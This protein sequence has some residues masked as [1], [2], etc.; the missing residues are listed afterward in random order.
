MNFE[1]L[2]DLEFYLIGYVIEDTVWT[3]IPARLSPAYIHP[4]EGGQPWRVPEI[5]SKT[6]N[7]FVYDGG[8]WDWEYTE[9][10]VDHNY[11][12]WARLPR[13]KTVE[14]YWGADEFH[15]MT[16][17]EEKGYPTATDIDVGTGI[18]EFPPDYTNYNTLKNYMES[19]SSGLWAIIDTVYMPGPEPPPAEN[20][21]GWAKTTFV[22]WVLPSDSISTGKNWL[23]MPDSTIGLLFKFERDTVPA[24]V[25][26]RY[27][28]YGISSWQGQCMN[29]PA[30][31]PALLPDGQG[32][33]FDFT[34][35]D[36]AKY[37]VAIYDFDTLQENWIDASS[38]ASLTNTSM[39]RYFLTYEL[40]FPEDSTEMHDI[41][42]LKAH[43]YGA[44]AIVSP[45]TGATETDMMK[46]RK[47][48]FGDSVWNVTVPRD[49]DNPL[50][51]REV[52]HGDMMADYWE[53]QVLGVGSGNSA[54]MDFVPFYQLEGQIIYA[55]KDKD[56][57]GRDIRGDGFCNWEE[58]RGFVTTGD[59]DGFYPAATPEKHVRL[60][61][62]VKN[63]MV[64]F[65]PGI[66][67]M[68][69]VPGYIDALPEDSMM[70]I[71]DHL[72][73]DSLRNSTMRYIDYNKL[74]ASFPYFSAFGYW[75]N[76]ENPNWGTTN[77]P[78]NYMFAGQPY[79]NAITFWPVLDWGN[80]DRNIEPVSQG[81]TRTS[82]PLNPGTLWAV[83]NRIKE[84][85]VRTDIINRYKNLPFYQNQPNDTAWV[86]DRDKLIKFTIAHEFG[87]GIGMYE[88]YIASPNSPY[89]M[90]KN[91]ADTLNGYRII[92]FPP[93]LILKYSINS[94][95]EI[96]IKEE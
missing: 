31:A 7:F 22:D 65:M 71:V 6:R 85:V 14:L 13:N 23:P 20:P 38:N 33:D 4:A 29:Y 54:I 58:Y 35:V 10:E 24:T 67:Y 61:P 44:R 94:K 21:P 59:Q 32:S 78:A 19:T 48:A 66:R 2:G 5:W 80:R 95:S 52:N 34:V 76:N 57:T 63:V 17:D 56:P 96:T 16:Y 1:A 69:E 73:M 92:T 91:H 55:D 51:R 39:R 28:I 72:V 75:S 41:L 60:L 8:G 50:Q 27:N 70:F 82:A 18:H 83:P 81:Y 40:E 15:G 37:T 43:D 26:I 36:T 3:I 47:T 30:D 88:E 49:D 77:M 42:W 86:N 53:E 45:A 89:I 84:M 11:D 90:R 9:T 62:H 68:A 74:G 12:I 79:Q 93:G 87:H 25:L 64:H 46:M